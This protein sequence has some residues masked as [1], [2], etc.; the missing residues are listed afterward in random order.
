MQAVP[1]LILASDAFFRE[2][3]VMKIFLQPFF[4]LKS[5]CQL[6]AKECMLSTSKLP[7][8]GVPRKLELFPNMTSAVY[9]GRIA[10]NQ[11]KQTNKSLAIILCFKCA[12]WL[13]KCS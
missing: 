13:A 7:L 9:H 6:M 3:L 1:R 5:N 4:L 10:S 2:D 11:I 12:G 8:G